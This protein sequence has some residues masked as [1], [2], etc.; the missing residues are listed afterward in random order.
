MPAGSESEL[1]ITFYLHEMP[2]A[3]VST[4][5]GRLVGESAFVLGYLKC[6]VSIFGQADGTPRR[7]RGSSIDVLTMPP[8]TA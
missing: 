7:R 8:I 5:G 3:F 6:L 2:G 1:G 4:S